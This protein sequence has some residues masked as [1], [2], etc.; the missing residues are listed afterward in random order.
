MTQQPSSQPDATAERYPLSYTQQYFLSLDEGDLKGAFGNRFTI[1]SGV[2]IAGHVDIPTLQGA[3]DDVVQRHELLRTVVV[4]DAQPPYQQV[5]PPCRVPL[6]VRDW[7]ATERSRDLMAEELIIEAEKGTMTPRQVPVMRA[8]LARFDDHDSALVLVVHHSASDAWS[9]NVI[10]HDLAAFYDAR[11]NHHPVDLSPVKQYRDYAEWQNAGTADTSDARQYW[12]E[13]LRGAHVLVLPNDR[14]RPEVYSRPF[15]AYNY[16]VSADEMAAACRFAAEARSSMF[17]VLMAA[18]SVF[19]YEMQGVAGPGIRAFTTGRNE[20]AFQNTMGLFL[21]LVPFRTDISRC[22][23]FREIVASTRDTCIDAYSNEVPITVI[24]QDVPD[25]NAPHDDPR[26]SQV[27]LG[28]YQA[29]S[30]GAELPIADGAYAIFERTLPSPET[31]DIPTGMA[32]SMAITGSGEL[33]GNVV[34]NLD[35]FDEQKVAGWASDY[36]RILSRLA[37]E[38]DREWRQ[39][40]DV[41]S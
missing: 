28:M 15:S 26:N 16:F 11:A 39:L 34:Y 17:M 4:R 10:L 6:D 5:C 24:E 8:T 21:N 25:F 40:A 1:V 30:D 3:L 9:Q 19:I 31:S 7:P 32:W 36:N 22:T 38:P 41:A 33:T 14:P 37:S 23:S 20:P 2:R 18:F 12:R 13:K 27:V 29:Q 35:E